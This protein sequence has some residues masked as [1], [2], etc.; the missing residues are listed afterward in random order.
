MDIPCGMVD[1]ISGTDAGRECWHVG[2]SRFLQDPGKDATI[3]LRSCNGSSHRQE[4]RVIQVRLGA[5][6]PQCRRNRD[7]SC[8]LLFPVFVAGVVWILKCVLI[9]IVPLRSLAM[10]PWLIDDSFIVMQIARNLALGRGYSFDGVSPTSGAPPLWTVL[11]SLNHFFLDAVGA[12]KATLMES[13]L[14]GAASA[15]LVF[16]LAYRFFDAKVAWGAFAFVVLSVPMFLNSMNGMETSLFTLL[17]LLSVYL[18]V[19]Y[20]SDE[21]TKARHSGFWVGACLGLTNLAR[22]DGVFLAL[23][24]VLLEAYALVG[25]RSEHRRDH[26]IQIVTLLAGVILFSLP[27]ALWSLRVAGTPLPANQ[28]GRRSLAWQGTQLAGG[29]VLWPAY[30]GRV[31]GNV[32]KMAVLLSLMAGSGFLGILSVVSGAARKRS[33]LLRELLSVYLV[34]YLGALI[35]YQG[36]FPDVHGIRYLNLPMHL[37]AI[38]VMAFCYEITLSGHRGAVVR[39]TLKLGVVLVLLLSSAYQYARMIINLP[40]AV[41]MR[42][43]PVYSDAEVRQWW[44]FVDWLSTHCPDGT[45]MAAKDHGR[46]AYFANAHVVDLA[47]IIDPA[48]LTAQTEGTLGSYLEGKEAEYVLLPDEGGWPVHEAIRASLDLDI[49]PGV[50]PQ[51]CTGYFLYRIRARESRGR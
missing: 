25:A 27:L 43:I 1:V 42:I 6:D 7:T 24:V 33:A 51:E 10:S 41:G 28:L 32:L 18:Y 8:V 35:V 38:L 26:A 9:A 31:I 49:V 40:W 13:S 30:A 12:A 47:G 20:R 23:A 3:A 22:A 46:L 39:Y 48:V 50:P 19:T 15:I 2:Q 44:Q 17:G 21:A 16:Y 37:L 36:Y 14:L 4:S 29:G 34:V 45:V 11:A 5:T